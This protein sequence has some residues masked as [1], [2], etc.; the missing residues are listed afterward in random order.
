MLIVNRNS[1]KDFVK[2]D[3][4]DL[5]KASYA[6]SSHLREHLK[7]MFCTAHFEQMRAMTGFAVPLRVP[8]KYLSNTDEL[9]SILE[10]KFISLISLT[11][12]LANQRKTITLSYLAS[13]KS[14]INKFACENDLKFLKI[15]KIFQRLI[16]EKM[17]N[18]FI[19]VQKR[20][21][22]NLF[23]KQQKL[24]RGIYSFLS[25]FIL[26]ESILKE[27]TLFLDLTTMIENINA[28]EMRSRP[29]QYQEYQPSKCFI[30]SKETLT[31]RSFLYSPCKHD[32][33]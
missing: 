16:Y 21:I 24:E 12:Q 4:V 27:I 25:L 31:I 30:C 10:N 15:S 2:E 19:Q 29:N 28:L 13:L 11:D 6:F 17:L 5:K 18:R 8:G 1:L 32:K 14:V 3:Q 23:Q 33:V 22:L 26:S 20:I 9:P 7:F